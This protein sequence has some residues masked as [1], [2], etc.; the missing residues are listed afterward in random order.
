[1]T[2]PP[3]RAVRLSSRRIRV[4]FDAVPLVLV[5]VAEAAWISVIA[6][7]VQEYA[8]RNTV[9]GITSLVLFVAA[10]VGAARLLG[11]R[12]GDRWPLVA[13]ALTVC[14]AAIGWLASPETR[15][16]LGNDDLGR[17]LAAHPGG[18][19]A[20]VAVLR[21]FAYARL[22]VA[23]A[24]VARLLTLGIPGLAVAAI[25]GG[26]V[27]EPWRGL[28]L[29][30]ALV[31]SI[32]FAASATLVLAFARLSSVGRDGGFDWRRNPSWAALLAMLVIAGVIVAVPLS[33]VAGTS[34]EM[35]LGLAIGPLLIV[36]LTFGLI[37]DFQRTAR[38]V[39]G[40]I[41]TAPLV[42]FL[43]NVFGRSGLAPREAPSG[44]GVGAI[45]NGTDQITALGLGGLAL[46]VAA[47][48][49]LVMARL[50]MR[51]IEVPEDDDLAET[52]SIDK[53]EPFAQQ[54]RGS[55]RRRR[56]TPSDAAGAYVALIDDLASHP[57]VRRAPAETPAE[58]A[59]RLRSGGQGDLSLELLAA[60]YALA[61]FGGVTLSDTEDRRALGRWRVLRRKLGRE[62]TR[63][64]PP[65][66]P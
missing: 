34:I 16:A 33:T 42:V 59:Q 22:P 4:I 24:T 6:A 13:L 25:A 64:R 48:A 14:G 35:L 12:L 5:V 9:L 38:I 41:V 61:R 20:G 44:S 7:L 55:S 17:A 50:W 8:L 31:A 26:A 1:M 2:A 58:H 15:A 37:A 65:G 52:R 3:G 11:R 40:V 57:V 19:L 21:G 62:A 23:E 63:H 51:R 66:S 18:W 39:L 43:V 32:V 53:G 47:V 49:I 60:D 27:T 56:S 54:G 45:S 46:L 36:G 29:A 28:F 10:G 30:D